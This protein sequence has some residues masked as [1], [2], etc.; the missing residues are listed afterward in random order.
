MTFFDFNSAESP[1]WKLF[2]GGAVTVAISICGWVGSSLN[3]HGIALE[4]LEVKLDGLNY[5]QELIRSSIKEGSEASER[6]NVRFSDIQ[7][8]IR[9]EVSALQQ[10]NRDRETRNGVGGLPSLLKGN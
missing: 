4:R 8:E 3:R 6:R 9:R 7:M 10:A 1:V 5:G 2:I